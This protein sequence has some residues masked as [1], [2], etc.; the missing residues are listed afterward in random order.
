MRDRTVGLFSS[1]GSRL[2]RTCLTVGELQN[3]RCLRIRWA[4][5]WH[6]LREKQK[7]LVVLRYGVQRGL[8]EHIPNRS[9]YPIY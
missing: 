7:D 1:D 2:I 9:R 3:G 4:A 8:Y 5:H 6:S